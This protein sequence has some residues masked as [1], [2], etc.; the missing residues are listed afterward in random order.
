MTRSYNFSAG[1]AVLPVEVLQQAQKEL[2]EWQDGVSA[3]EH[4]HRSHT[5]MELAETLRA[6]F[7]EAL[8]IPK[9]YQVL[10]MAGGGTAQFA[11]V[12]LN[13]LRE[14]T[15]ADYI[16]TGFW[17]ERSA[18]EAK[19]YCEVNIAASNQATHY[20]TIPAFNTWKLNPQAAYVHYAA[21]ETIHGV[22]F[23][24][25][26]QTGNVPLVADMSSNILSKPINV[27]DYALIYAA[28]QKNIAPAGFTLVIVRED[29][30]GHARPMTPAVL[31]YYRFITDGFYNTPVT[32]AF[33][34]AHLALLWL[35]KK[36]GVAAMAEINQ[37]K[38]AK[39]YQAI[40][41]SDGFYINK[42]EPAYRSNMNIPFSIHDAKLTEDF[43]RLA[44]DEGLV[45]LRGHKATGGL[46]ASLYN[47][48]PIEGVKA[49]TDF[50]QYFARQNG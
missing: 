12:P 9:N 13:L 7:R 25:V 34:F 41:K 50:M 21:N 40:D 4:S 45:N 15:T 3:L 36:G 27:N 31:D 48:M 38:S 26:P 22:E 17:S 43:I 32:F 30:I 33:Y 20:Q 29:L 28:A 24:F 23:P 19:L 37:Q 18:A 2:L 47:A 44:A 39:L 1:P 6:Q 11:A 16:T 35:Q 46:R 14:K 10:F 5:F 8:N 49:L 42:V